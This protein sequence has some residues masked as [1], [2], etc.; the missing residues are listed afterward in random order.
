MKKLKLMNTT[1]S[2]D[3]VIKINEI[4]EEINNINNQLKLISG[5]VNMLYEQFGDY[6]CEKEDE[7]DEN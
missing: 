4:I 2:T 3:E 7:E 1:L 6:I 5:F